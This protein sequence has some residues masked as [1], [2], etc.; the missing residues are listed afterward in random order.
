MDKIRENRRENLRRLIRN[1]RFQR[2]FA[3][4]TGVAAPHVS[5]LLSGVQA[6]GEDIALRIE[7][8]LGLPAGF[9]SL[10]PDDDSPRTEL[11]RLPHDEVK[12]LTDYRRVSPKHQ[13]IV[14][15][16]VATYVRENDK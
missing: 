4:E 15:E 5:Q 12:L 2:Q 9:M 10:D 11:Q 14:R 7:R 16:M 6:M 8:A 1:Y 3:V 13:E